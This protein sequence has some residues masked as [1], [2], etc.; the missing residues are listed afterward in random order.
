MAFPGA[1]T[2]KPVAASAI[3]SIP[4][5][6]PVMEIAAARGAPGGPPAVPVTVTVCAPAVTSVTVAGPGA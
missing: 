5:L 6:V 4:G 1:V 3:T 2:V